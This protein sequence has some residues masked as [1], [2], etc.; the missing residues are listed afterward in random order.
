M[1]PARR[2]RPQLP[3]PVIVDV[4]ENESGIATRLE[5]L[6]ARVA[7]RRLTVGDYLLARS[8][9][10][11]RKRVID[12]HTSV[13]KG[14]FWEQITKLQT[15]CARPYLLVEGTD[16]D[17]GPLH[18]TTIRSV[19]LAVIEKGIPV[20]R[21]YQQ[22]DSA[23]WLH[24][25]ALRSHRGPGSNRSTY[26]QKPQPAQGTPAA[27]ALLAA[28][29]G[30]S[31]AS[32]RALLQ[33]FGSVG[34]VMEAGPDAWLEVPGIGPGRVRALEETLHLSFSGGAQ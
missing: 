11:E 28:V 12:L 9:R 4:Y 21:S 7:V 2:S 15:G 24:R 1:P 10:V 32:A 30:I 14:R 5:E 17:R 18:P 16:I 6:G 31:T 22:R 8:T 26:A 3:P 27:E 23:V 33:R 19:C 25:L 34:E 20:L 13:G 29:P